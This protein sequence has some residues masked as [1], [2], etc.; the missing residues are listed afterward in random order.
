M[1]PIVRFLGKGA[2]A[3]LL[4]SIALPPALAAPGD[5]TLL[6]IHPRKGKGNAESE[7]P[8]LSANGRFIAFSSHATNLHAA[9]RDD[10]ADIFVADRVTGKVRLVSITADGTKGNWDSYSP[11]ISDDGTK[12]VFTSYSDNIHPDDLDT[13]TDVYVKDLR[14]GEL[15]LVSTTS[16]E[17]KSNNACYNSVI[18]G[19][20]TAVAFHT[21]A[22]NLDARDTDGFE[23]VYV[24]DLLTGDLTLATAGTSGNKG[25]FFSLYPS[26]SQDGSRVTFYTLSNNWDPRD[27]DFAYDVYVKDVLTGEMIL[28]ST[29]DAGVKSNTNCFDPQ[30][31]GDG[32]VVVFDS[33]ATNLDAGDTDSLSDVYWKDLETGEMRLVSAAASGVKG[34]S[35]S[36]GSAVSGDGTMVTFLSWSQNLDPAD[37]DDRVD[38]FRKNVATGAISLATSSDTGVKGN[39]ETL[40]AT[41]S[42]NGA[43]VGFYTQA[44]NLDP[45]D[46][47]FTPDVY[48]KELP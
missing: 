46:G 37:P 7:Y 29:S 24:K 40:G 44:T 20:G 26:I 17:E 22:T 13:Y 45:K 4:L 42:A 2:V 16:S 28:A 41:V 25:N 11:G 33:N 38:A 39:A 14:T 43:F 19:D 34:N 21:L 5:L 6:S 9:D 31:S 36:Y 18:S 23:D 15:R 27:T 1:E 48:V 30:I 32:T 47:D 35:Y 10:I 8:S 3:A 12:V